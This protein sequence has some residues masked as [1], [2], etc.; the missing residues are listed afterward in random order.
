MP[1]GFVPNQDV[2]MLNASTEAPQDVSFDG[3]V[4]MQRQVAD[5][6]RSSPYIEAFMSSVSNGNAGRF[7][8]RLKPL[9]E[10]RLT[11]EQVIESLRP[12]LNAL[13]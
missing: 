5:V 11:P 9:D 2:G 3:M 4:K 10:R 6:L 12:K 8:V 7:I 1:K 13:P